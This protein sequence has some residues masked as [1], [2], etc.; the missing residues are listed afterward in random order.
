MTDADLREAV[1]RAMCE[2]EAEEPSFWPHYTDLADA[3]IALVVAR[4]AEVADGWAPDRLDIC[5]GIVKDIRA[6]APQEPSHD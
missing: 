1:A 6:L 5:N 2:S 3:A 4:C